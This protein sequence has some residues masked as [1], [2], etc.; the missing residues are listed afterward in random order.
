M[1][2]RDYPPTIGGVAT[3]VESTAACLRNLGVDVDVYEGK[4]N[5]MTA[6]LPLRQ[7]L[8][9]SHYDL[10][11]VQSGPFG[12]LARHPL[13]VTLHATILEE[14]KYY[15][16][17]SRMR[18]FVAYMLERKALAQ[19]DAITTDSRFTT[20]A[21]AE[22]YGI[23]PRK[24]FLIP[25]G[26]DIGR[27]AP[28]I[29]RSDGQPRI[30]ICSRLVPRKNIKE[31]LIAL[32]FFADE[33][34]QLTIVGDGPERT[35]LEQVARRTIPRARFTGPVSQ[36]DL[37]GIF[38]SSTIFI[39]SSRSEGFGLSVLQAMASGL[40][41]I[42]SD[43]PA[44]RELITHETDGLLY[45]SPADLARSL[46]LLLSDKGLVERLGANARRRALVHS[47]E[48]V[49][50]SIVTVYRQVLDTRSGIRS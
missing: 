48:S 26:V 3:V 46:K 42:A 44:H 21:L 1:I 30:L 13:V 29:G 32:S 31:A 10:I 7:A 5:S 47:W 45:S 16:W 24:I 8:R 33:R 34:F 9:S 17:S 4:T 36:K 35:Y 20:K 38:S 25:L 12:A 15:P 41:V 14:A 37:C 50:E 39:S 22:D 40:A 43:I 6:I 19:A 49:A 28:A 2:T 18:A 11:H 23:D 27:F